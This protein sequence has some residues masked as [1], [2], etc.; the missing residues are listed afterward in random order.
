MFVGDYAI[1]QWEFERYLAAS[2]SG[3]EDYVVTL[4]LQGKTR[5][6]LEYIDSVDVDVDD[7]NYEW[8]DQ[9][10]RGLRAMILYSRGEFA[11]ADRVFDEL[12]SMQ[13]HD[14]RM[15]SLTVTRAAAW[16]GKKD[17]A[18][19]KLFEM[20]ASKFQYLHRKT[21]SPA[22]QNLH[23]DP[24]WL[25]YREF[26]GTSAERLDAIEFDPDLPE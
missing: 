18:F 17:L 13:V 1:A 22:W 19:E 25:E 12:M 21:F 5:E 3:W 10:V 23:D 15:L 16:M 20:A 4:L 6:A 9:T 24:R 7:E 14:V 8:N 11:E 26:N 2:D